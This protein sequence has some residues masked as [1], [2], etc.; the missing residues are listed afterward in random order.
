MQETITLF[1]SLRWQDILDIVLVALL[2]YQLL[3]LV[4][5][6]RAMHLLVGLAL[7]LLLMFIS[8]FLELWTLYWIINSF[9][10]SIIIILVILFQADIKRVLS[11]LGQKSSLGRLLTYLTRKTSTIVKSSENMVEEVVRSAVSLASTMTGGLMVIERYSNLNDIAE[12]GCILD[13][14]V[15]RELLLTIFRV[16]TP[17]HDGAVII[18]SNRIRS[19]RCLLPL[20]SN[21]NLARHLGTRHRAAVGITEETDAVCVVVSEER[22][23][24]SVAAT[25][26]I[27]PDLDA[28]ALR[29]L[30]YELLNIEEDKRNWWRILR[31]H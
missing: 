22:G 31:G 3:L 29:R 25:G 9:V 24:I 6:T 8:Q 12:D 17:L 21:P 14:L 11:R 16:G 30:L 20:S 1:S 19:A 28:V 18:S 13:C 15:N 27:H 5:G 2:L 10:A 26:Q 23:A 7:V 4:R